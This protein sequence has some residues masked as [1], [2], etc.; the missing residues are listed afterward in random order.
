MGT[1][2]LYIIVSDGKYFVFF[3]PWDSYPHDLGE[4]IVYEL[5]EIDDSTIENGKGY[6]QSYMK[7]TNGMKQEATWKVITETL[8]CFED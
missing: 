2:G 4:S 7:S 8:I 3:S 5:R 1:H 6:Y